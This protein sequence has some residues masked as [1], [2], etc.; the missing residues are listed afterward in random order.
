M[1]G[2]SSDIITH[3]LSIY[4]EVRPIA[5]KKQKMGEEKRDV[6]LQDANKLVKVGFIRKAHYTT[7]L[8]NVVIVNKSNGKWRMCVDYIDLNKA[9][10]KDSYLCRT[11]IGS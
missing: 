11:L 4:K 1:L 8:A 3:R 5:Q 6:S 9:C 7:C 10:P 2:A